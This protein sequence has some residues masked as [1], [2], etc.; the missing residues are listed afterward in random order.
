[1]YTRS[2]DEERD[3]RAQ[4]GG[5]RR[6]A[7]FRARSRAPPPRRRARRT[8]GAPPPS[9]VRRSCSSSSLRLVAPSGSAR[10]DRIERPQRKQGRTNDDSPTAQRKG[11]EEPRAKPSATARRRASHQSAQ[12]K[13]RQRDRGRKEDK[14]MKK[15]VELRIDFDKTGQERVIVARQT[16]PGGRPCVVT[17][18]LT[19]AMYRKLRS[20][21][22]DLSIPYST[23]ASE[24][25]GQAI[26]YLW[27]RTSQCND[28]LLLFD[29]GGESKYNG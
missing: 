25:L 8:R 10:Q 4:G 12:T 15:H 3:G 7:R 9:L 22:D 21:A 5:D 16:P 17:S 13:R 24:I 19:Q 18:R 1:M 23:M 28:Q 2:G 29:D 27:R 20:M 6:R 26:E 14:S 11:T